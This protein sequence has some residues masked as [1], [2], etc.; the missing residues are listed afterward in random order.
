[1]IGRWLWRS[2]TLRF[3][4]LRIEEINERLNHLILPIYLDIVFSSRWNSRDRNRYGM[5]W[6][7][8][9]K[10]KYYRLLNTITV[11]DSKQ[12][13]EVSLDTKMIE[14]TSVHILV[15]LQNYTELS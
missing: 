9:N 8:S 4:I 5:I 12:L 11:R 13:F 10:N 15:W 2:Q 6:F 1:M 7:P 14:S 3:E